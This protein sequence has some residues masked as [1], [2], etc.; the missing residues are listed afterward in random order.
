MKLYEGMRDKLVFSAF[1]TFYLK[2]YLKFL[3]SAYEG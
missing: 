3:I 2:S 1:L